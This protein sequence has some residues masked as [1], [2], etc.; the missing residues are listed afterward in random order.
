LEQNKDINQF[1]IP[2]AKR[3]YLKNSNLLFLK[4]LLILSPFFLFIFSMVALRLIRNLELGPFPNLNFQVERNHEHRVLGH[5]PYNEIPKEKLVLIEPN[6]EVHI[7][8]HDSLLKMREEAKKDG[9]YLVFLSG[10]RSIDLQ[11]DIFYSLKSIRNQEA[12][13]RARVSAPPGYSEHSTGFAIDIGDATQRETDFE[14]EFENTKAFKWLIKNAAK[15]HFKLSFNKDNKYI[16]YEPWHWRYE[17][18][19]EALKIFESSNRK[20]QI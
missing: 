14:T 15:F 5:L 7:D 16:D 6:I 10:Y 1:D 19:I 9:I 17:G 18:S 2:L 4:K 3:T 12:A 8:M 20:L 13:E 11:K